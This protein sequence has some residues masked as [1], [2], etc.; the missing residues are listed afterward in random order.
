M[1]RK[2]T[3]LLLLVLVCLVSAGAAHAAVR[4]EVSFRLGREGRSA[5]YY[6]AFVLPNG[7]IVVSLYTQ[8]RIG[9]GIPSASGAYQTCVVCIN[10]QNEILWS[11]Y[12][13]GSTVPGDTVVYSV[14]RMSMSKEGNLD[15]LLRQRTQ[16][17]GAYFLP[18]TLAP[19]TGEPLHTG[20]RLPFEIS[21]DAA[22]RFVTTYNLDDLYVQQKKADFSTAD[23]TSIVY[24]YDYENHL[25]WSIPGDELPFRSVSACLQ[26]P[27]GVLLSGTAIAYN[28]EGRINSY[29]A[30]GNGGAR[31]VALDAYL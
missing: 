4:G 25:L 19:D 8:D 13:N 26:T 12:F 20:T 29:T 5:Q 15:L 1:K 9:P 30:R 6:P 27:A 24:A 23:S 18:V 21:D 22:D 2:Y 7:N 3:W 16:Q 31:Q 17:D 11:R 10:Q 28:E 14:C